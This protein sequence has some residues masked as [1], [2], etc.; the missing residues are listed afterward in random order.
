MSSEENEQTPMTLNDTITTAKLPPAGNSD[1]DTKPEDEPSNLLYISA[2]EK[3]KSLTQG[4]EGNQHHSEI[5]AMESIVK[6]EPQTPP[7]SVNEMVCDTQSA[8]SQLDRKNA[9]A[10]QLQT[11]K[12]CYSCS[13]VVDLNQP[14]DIKGKI[15]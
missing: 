8:S 2:I 3:Q 10:T 7:S 15:Y 6:T 13:L 4:A 11:G 9:D 5:D 1:G 12:Y 14:G